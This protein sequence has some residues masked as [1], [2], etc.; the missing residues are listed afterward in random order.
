MSKFE[1][2]LTCPV[3]GEVNHSVTFLAGGGRI[4]HFCGHETE[5]PNGA[6]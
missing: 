3:C 5:D 1:E 4:F 2:M 6:Q